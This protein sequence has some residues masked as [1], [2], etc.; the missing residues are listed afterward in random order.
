MSYLDRIVDNELDR[1]LQSSGVVVI[2]GPKAVGK[3]STARQRSK[4]EVLFDVDEGARAAA[5][6]N[7]T[8]VL[9]GATPR[10]I[11]EWQTVPAI[12]NHV[13][14]ASDE[15]GLPGQFILTG[16]AVA[17][18][19]ITRHT[20]AGRISRVLMRPMSLFEAGHSDGTVSLGD[21]MAGQPVAAVDPGVGLADVAEW[22]V[23]GG[24]PATVG[25]DLDSA[26]QYVRD[27]VDEIR[28]TDVVRIDGVTRDPALVRILLRSLARNTATEATLR[29]LAADVG[30]SE[31][32]LG[33]DTV[34]DHLNALER[35][36][37]VEPQPAWMPS[38]RSK[39]KLRTTPKRHFVDPSI[40]V[41]AMRT[42][43]EQL[44]LDLN[45]LGLMFES[46]VVR[47]LRV[48]GQS[49]DAEVSHY[50]DNTGLEVDAVVET[51]RGDWAAFE[52]KLGGEAN[53]DTAAANLL[54]FRERVDTT[55]IGEPQKLV[56]VTATGYAYDRPD[57]VAVVPL[58]VLRA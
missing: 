31:H 29:T 28:R 44:L 57:G 12:W 15:R 2:E 34:R 49:L 47:D 24:W 1:R 3:T 35:L 21:L 41:A 48:Y 26:S 16:S 30:G 17:G 33:I 46:L 56:V 40:A 23:R 36:F 52:V 43:K 18:D 6:V 42:T 13:R 5:L 22:I 14:R 53:I 11:D 25:A 19:D 20:G 10:L 4:S 50:R 32:P 37:V 51:A 45:T 55:V 38:L 58:G 39:S 7:P 8:L 54:R 9:E 27:Y